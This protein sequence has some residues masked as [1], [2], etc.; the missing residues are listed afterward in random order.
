MNEHKV[1]L[2]KTLCPRYGL[3]V[4]YKNTATGPLSFGHKAFVK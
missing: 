4:F 3:E 1:A 2:I